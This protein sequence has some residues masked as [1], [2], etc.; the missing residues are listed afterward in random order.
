MNAV[1]Y[2][3]DTHLNVYNPWAITARSIASSAVPATLAQEHSYS[4]TPDTPT[5]ESI[6]EGFDSD[7]EAVSG[8][9]P[10]NFK[11]HEQRRKLHGVYNKPKKPTIQAPKPRCYPAK[12]AQPVDKDVLLDIC[13]TLLENYGTDNTFELQELQ[14]L[15]HAKSY[16]GS[17]TCTF[18]S[19]RKKLIDWFK[20][21]NA[22]FNTNYKI[23]AKKKKFSIIAE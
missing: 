14:N 15:D 17:D 12:R 22:H 21:Y 13:L 6:T 5:S 9:Q 7:H 4:V 23:S 20:K 10:I 18:H 8:A 3:P 11:P 16:F 1:T 2:T 19:A